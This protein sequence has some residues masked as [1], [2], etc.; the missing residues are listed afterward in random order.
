MQSDAI[1]KRLAD[2]QPSGEQVR[3]SLG[4]FHVSPGLVF[5]Q[6]AAGYRQLQARAVFRWRDFVAEQERA[7]DLLDVDQAILDRFEGLSVLHETPRG[8]FGIGVGAI[9]GI[10]YRAVL[11]SLNP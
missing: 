5:P 8:L 6:P 1:A 2:F 11:T 9:G 4:E 3:A 10:L 7:V